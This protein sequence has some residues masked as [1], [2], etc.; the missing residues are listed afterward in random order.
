MI[1][2]TDI[3]PNVYYLSNENGI[4]AYGNKKGV[5][6]LKNSLETEEIKKWAEENNIK[7]HWLA[8]P[9]FFALGCFLSSEIK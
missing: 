4:I 9:E 1:T 7:S 5:S 8:F 6:Y 2:R 3:N